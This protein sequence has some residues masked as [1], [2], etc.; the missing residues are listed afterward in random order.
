VLVMPATD[1]EYALAVAERLRARLESVPLKVRGSMLLVQTASI[2]V[3]TWDRQEDAATLEERADLAMY[4]AKRRGRN[5]VVVAA[6]PGDSR[7][8]TVS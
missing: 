8:L 6:P 5:R 1:E 2:G 7:A 3:A 4:E